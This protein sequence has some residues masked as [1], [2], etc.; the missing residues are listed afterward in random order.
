M[1]VRCKFRCV[2]RKEIASSYGP[3]AE[4]QKTQEAIVLQAVTGP[5][6]ESWSKWTPS[7]RLEV[8]ITN[9]T[10]LDVFKVGEEYYLDVYPVPEG[11]CAEGGGQ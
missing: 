2:E 11:K 10:A 7:G 4:G 1:T 5:G 3:K 6:N 8:Q 9:P